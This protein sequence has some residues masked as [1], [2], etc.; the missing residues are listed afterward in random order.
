MRSGPLMHLLC[1]ATQRGT[2]V[3]GLC[4]SHSRMLLWMHSTEWICCVTRC[5]PS[6]NGRHVICG[7]PFSRSSGIPNVCWRSGSTLTNGLPR[8]C[9]G[10]WVLLS[11]RNA[12]WR[13][14]G[15][16][17]KL[18]PHSRK[19]ADGSTAQSY[20]VDVMAVTVV[21]TSVTRQYPHTARKAPHINIKGRNIS[22]M[23]L[24]ETNTGALEK[25]T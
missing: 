16:K 17:H 13:G 1:T 20:V 12:F 4:L 3:A 22:S 7:M 6:T 2:V 25:S 11:P 8:R 5:Y 19:W 23:T 10:V 15:K 21:A 14:E 24:R 9:V 18:R